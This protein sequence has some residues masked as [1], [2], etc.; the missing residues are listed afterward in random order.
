MK[1]LI[2]VA[3]V[4]LAILFCNRPTK[5]QVIKDDSVMEFIELLKA[6]GI[7]MK[8]PADNNNNCFYVPTEVYRTQVYPLIV[9]HN[10]QK[11]LLFFPD[12]SCRVCLFPKVNRNK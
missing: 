2:L 7:K 5:N 6:K 11:Y 8:H 3:L 9:Q 12:S 1:Q 10:L 4:T